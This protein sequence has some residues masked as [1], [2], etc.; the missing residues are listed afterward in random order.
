MKAEKTT[1]ARLLLAALVL[2]SVFVPGPAAAK[3]VYKGFLDAAVPQHRAIL[4]TLA[5]IEAAPE[6]PGLHNDLGCLL[7]FEGYWKDALL[8]F[9]TAVT[10]AKKENKST[11][12][13]LDHG[14]SKP[15]FNAGLVQ[16]IKGEWG[17]ARRSF[18]KAVDVNPG[19]WAAWWML[20]FAREQLG[21]VTA[22]VEAYKRSLRVDTSLFDVARN[23]FVARSN[24]KWRVLLETYDQ[25]L[26]KA[27]LPFSEQWVDPARIAPFFQK[28]RAAAPGAATAEEASPEPSTASGPVVTSVPQGGTSS[29]GRPG[30]VPVRGAPPR[31][32]EQ[33]PPPPQPQPEERRIV[34][35]PGSFDDPPPP[36]LPTPG[37]GPGG[38]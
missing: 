4:D 14:A 5:R 30:S 16:A 23:P 21:H 26:V 11:T 15:Y 22:A 28:A 31:G 37:P 29:P 1:L 3:D 6:D 32:F 36:K 35:G 17:A 9:D 2:G 33:L 12:Y 20:G 24:L 19:N 18:G 10:L 25:R 13:D 8:E 27:S 38:G 7:V 34:P